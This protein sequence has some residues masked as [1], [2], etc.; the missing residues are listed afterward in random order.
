MAVRGSSEAPRALTRGTPL[1]VSRSPAFAPYGGSPSEF[2]S[3]LHCA[4]G[5]L[6]RPFDRCGRVAVRMRNAHLEAR[7]QAYPHREAKTSAALLRLLEQQADLS[8]RSRV[9]TQGE[10][11]PALHV[12]VKPVRDLG[13]LPSNSDPHRNPRSQSASGLPPTTQAHEPHSP[14]AR[15]LVCVPRA[16][17][18]AGSSRA[19]RSAP[20]SVSGFL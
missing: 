15:R 17:A 11:R 9:P 1:S 3:P 12:A 7:R 5:A 20:P 16:E 2:Q 19:Q 4:G 14:P 6:Q 8:D 13:L 10:A 18:M